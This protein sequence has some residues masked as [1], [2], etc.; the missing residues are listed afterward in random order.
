MFEIDENA[1][2]NVKCNGFSDNDKKNIAME[3]PDITSYD[4]TGN[5]ILHLPATTNLEEL[6]NKVIQ[7]YVSVLKDF[8]K[9]ALSSPSSL[10]PSNYVLPV[11]TFAQKTETLKSET[12]LKDITLKMVMDRILEEKRQNFHAHEYIEIFKSEI[13]PNHT[14]TRR[15]IA[16]RVYSSITQLLKAKKIFVSDH[17][18]KRGGKGGGRFYSVDLNYINTSTSSTTSSLITKS[19]PIKD[20]ILTDNLPSFR[21]E[22]YCSESFCTE[23]NLPKE[24]IFQQVSSTV[25]AMIDENLVDR[26]GKELYTVKL[27]TQ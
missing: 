26:F 5:L 8:S 15:K 17:P 11:S 7:A 14:S 2:I 10:K 12:F 6:T 24:K 27:Y 18:S 19:N 22:H 9:N 3:L 25:K 4:E 1:I 13:D 16:G 23:F 21:L 20:R